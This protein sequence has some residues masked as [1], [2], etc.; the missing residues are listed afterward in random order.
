MPAKKKAPK[1]K[2]GDLCIVYLKDHCFNHWS[3]SGPAPIKVP[4][5]F[6]SEEADHYRFE[7]FKPFIEGN[8]HEYTGGDSYTVVKHAGLIIYKVTD[9]R[10]VIG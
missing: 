3:Q 1:I 9:V 10:K 8:E 6:I 5:F 4:G 7:T 2:P